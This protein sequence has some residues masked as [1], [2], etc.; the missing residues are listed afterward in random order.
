MTGDIHSYLHDML[1]AARSKS[2]DEL[3]TYTVEQVIAG[4]G[5]KQA[6]VLRKAA[7]PRWVDASVLRVLRGK[8]DGNERVLEMLR[9]YSFVRDLGDGRLAY[10]DEVRKALLEEWR[11]DHPDELL[12]LHR[13]LYQHFS[14][15]TTPPGTTGRAMP[16]MPDSNLLSVVPMNAQADLLRREAIYHLLQFDQRLGLR[17]L[18]SNFAYLEEA[19]RLAEAELLLQMAGETPL[20]PGE[21]R[22][23]QYLRARALQGSLNLEAAAE[24][25]EGLRARG[26]L[27]PELAAEVSRTQAEVYAETGQWARATELYRQSLAHFAR[28][29]NQRSA[30][31]T[32]LLLGEAYQGLGVSTGSW[33]A[34][35]AFGNPILRLLHGIWIWILGLP[36]RIAIMIMGPKSRMLPLPE[37]CARYQNWLLIR[38]YNTAR[39][40][41]AQARDAFARL[42]D[43]VGTLRADQHLADI[44][45]IYGYH[46]EARAQ[47]EGLLKGAEARDPY[48]RA[49]LQRSL[50]ECHLAAGDVGS[51]QILLAQALEVF[52]ELGDVRREAVVRYLQG[53]AAMLAGD[54]E[55]ALQNYTI[56]LE[57]FRALRYAA[58]RERIL[59][60]LRTWKRDRATSP[61]VI[62]RI[63]RLIAAEPEKRY[64]GRFIRSYLGLL[65]VATLI[66]LP[67]A[68]FL[69]AVASPT[70]SL[71][72]NENGVFSLG[73]FFDPWR[74]LGVVATIT[75]I[76][77]AVYAA[78]A[79]SV[80]FWLPI[81]RIE[82]EQPDVIITKPESIAR[83][84]SMGNLDLEQPWRH[85]R[86]WFA[87][88]RCLWERPLA[89]YSRTYLEDEAGRD[90]PI[91][92]I[93][94]WYSELQRDIALRLTVAGQGVTR[95]DLGYRLLR[96]AMG[97]LFVVGALLLVIVTSS[98]NGWLN[99]GGLV[100]PPLAA[101]IWFVAL[102]GV[103]MLI[104]LAYWI[105]NRPLKLQRALL[106]NDR[107]PLVLAVIGA[108]PIM[109]YVLAGDRLIRID[110]LNFALFVWGVYVLAEALVALIA[111]GR[112]A[113]RI[114]LVTTAALVAIIF[115]ARP[116]LANYRWLESYVARK[117]VQSGATESASSCSAATE[118]RDLG[119]SAFET[120]MIQGDCAS[121]L[122]QW[123]QAAE[124]YFQAANVAP[125]G[126]G[127]QALALYNLSV[128]LSYTDDRRAYQQALGLYQQLCSDSLAARPVC[129]QLF[130]Q[131]LPG[132]KNLQ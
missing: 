10:H 126:S 28:S 128:A 99:L 87:L 15:R 82:R 118:A 117:Q 20:G 18:R 40:W 65:Q 30:A 115:M 54:V 86:R 21:R 42:G 83:Y 50:A 27:E 131:G 45:L 25:L 13:R 122:G 106:L 68:M 62:E 32:M 61:Q 39:A 48:R 19:H 5:P 111:P 3:L 81:G 11:R 75:P 119:A 127:D 33:H 36:F 114:A 58:A 91:D 93:T 73:L 90:L 89:L 41:Y 113:L 60:E 130:S 95:T 26:D 123:R 71:T 96:S 16:L 125:R 77:L 110:A 132:E 34:P 6:E 66:A 29:G 24:Q 112:G 72:L 79:V 80:I 35:I 103:L 124:Y 129:N 120:Y 2:G 38:L 121:E 56:G 92:G 57:R 37:H 102:S 49:W 47:I 46:E 22:W 97:L 14:Q 4:V 74:S 31:E 107:W 63:E 59:H 85:V 43:P 104:P 9:E 64:V 101:L 88:D 8:D 108:L 53:R 52:K 67:L 109:N 44:L 55:S 7:V 98:N 116:A 1:G 69:M 105:A 76:Y 12:L 51:A 84:D 70:A 17:E 100:P 23:V 94:G 78:I